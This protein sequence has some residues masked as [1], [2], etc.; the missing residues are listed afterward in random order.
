MKPV[1]ISILLIL[2]FSF[3]Y[4]QETYGDVYIYNLPQNY[5]ITQYETLELRMSGFYQSQIDAFPYVEIFINDIY[6]SSIYIEVDPNGGVFYI[7]EKIES[8]GNLRLLN[9]DE[10]NKF[11]IKLHDVLHQNEPIFS[12]DH[13]IFVSSGSSI[14]VEA[15]DDAYTIENSIDNYNDSILIADEVSTVFLKFDISQIKN[16]K[17][18]KL[19]LFFIFLKESKGNLK[20]YLADNNWDESSLNYFNQPTIFTE[21]GALVEYFLPGGYS[22]SLGVQMPKLKNLLGDRDTLSLAIIS[23]NILKIDAEL[24]IPEMN[25][26]TDELVVTNLMVRESV[27]NNIFYPNPVTSELRLIEKNEW[28]LLD[29]S[30]RVLKEGFGES[31]DFRGLEIGYYIININGRVNKVLKV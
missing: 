7:E 24:N 6:Y 17:V 12:N 5:E 9:K 14:I 28:V 13:S 31:I 11:T 20:V 3:S 8:L 22:G 15:I 23:D 4:G 26:L 10:Y 19:S 2:S 25:F 21:F 1:L 27:E 16:I 30:G 29:L 18:H